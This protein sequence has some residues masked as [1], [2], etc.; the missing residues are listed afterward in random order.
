MN[1]KAYKLA[2]REFPSNVNRATETNKSSLVNKLLQS[3][4]W[5]LTKGFS[6]VSSWKHSIKIQ[7]KTVKSCGYTVLENK[8]KQ[9]VLTLLLRES[10]SQVFLFM[11][12]L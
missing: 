5:K 11:V 10:K 7:K 2:E 6:Q 3:E 8:W 12:V 1:G 4:N 9:K